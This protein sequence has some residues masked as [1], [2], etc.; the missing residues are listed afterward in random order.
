VPF[1]ERK[2]EEMY[3]SM[4]KIDPVAAEKTRAKM[5]ESLPKMRADAARQSAR[6]NEA[7]AKRRAAFEAYRASLTPAQLAAPGTISGSTT[8]DGATRIDDP[9]GRPLARIDP[10]FASGN[11]SRIE[12]IAVSIAPQPKTDPEYAWQQASYE[13]LDYAALARL[14]N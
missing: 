2:I 3:Q 14:L 10:A 13:A 1:D 7:V 4:R 5:L 12:V 11:P 6:G 9:K 8:R